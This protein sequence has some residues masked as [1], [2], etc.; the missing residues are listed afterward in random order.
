MSNRLNEGVFMITAFLIVLFIIGIV[1]FAS[2]PSTEHQH[3]G[4]G[5]AGQFALGQK[6]RTYESM[7]GLRP[8]EA[9]M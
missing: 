4:F 6:F 3:P 9:F 5:Y 2:K 1:Y 8:P 7:C